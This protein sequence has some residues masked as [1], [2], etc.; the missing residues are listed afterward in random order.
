MEQDTFRASKDK[1]KNREGEEM[2]DKIREIGMH[3]INGGTMDIGDGEF[4][5]IGGGGKS[6]IDYVVTIEEGDEI[7]EEMEVGTNTE[8]DHQPLI[9]TIDKKYNRQ[10]KRQRKSIMDWSAN[11]V[12]EFKKRLSKEVK[13]GDWTEIKGKI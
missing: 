9:V 7:I 10:A 4:T 11:A 6:T 2:L 8:S 13:N 5:Y 3:I 1:I 12:I